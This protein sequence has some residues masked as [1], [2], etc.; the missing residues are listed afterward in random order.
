MTRRP[1]H[2]RRCYIVPHRRGFKY[3]RAVP[4]DLQAIEHKQAWVKCLGVIN[5]REAETLAH[6]LAYEHDRRI[7]ALRAGLA[8]NDGSQI[9][10]EARP[11]PQVI[12]PSLEHPDDISLTQLVDLWLRIRGPRSPTSIKAMNR[13]RPPASRAERCADPSADNDIVF[14]GNGKVA[15][16]GKS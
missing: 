2:Y 14:G 15:S 9:S 3:L 4:K 7:E 11:T 5:R 8:C 6:A 1:M 13:W 12:Q 16:A 10:T